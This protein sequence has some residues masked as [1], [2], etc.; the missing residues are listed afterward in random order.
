[1]SIAD[2]IWHAKCLYNFVIQI[3]D[4]EVQTMKRAWLS[5]MTLMA[6]LMFAGTAPANTITLSDPGNRY[7]NGGPFLGDL[8][9]TTPD[10]LIGDPFTTFCLEKSEYINFG[11][12]Y[13]Y[14]ISDYA[15]EGGGGATNG[16]DYLD[17]TSAWLYYQLR[18]GALDYRGNSYDQQALQ[19]AF[20]AIEGEQ[21]LLSGPTETIA[22]QYIS[23]AVAAVTGGWHNNGRVVVLNLY[24]AAGA[25]KQSQ[26]G[27]VPEPATL[28][29]IGLG[30]A[31]IGFS[32]RK[33][34]K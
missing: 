17:E 5:A 18:M 33:L 6:V 34:R 22:A 16:K 12:A 7:Y 25:N 19:A 21:S 32:S 13:N 14:R 27:M 1:M 29:L 3:H 30:L 15:E 11:V 2:P 31:G 20:W 24:D 10:A 8:N 4:R 23:D 26:L 28:L 9:K